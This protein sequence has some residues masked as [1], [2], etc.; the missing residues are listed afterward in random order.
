[1][2]LHELLLLRQCLKNLPPETS[3]PV[4]LPHIQRNK[5]SMYIITIKA[6]AFSFKGIVSRY[7]GLFLFH[8][9][10]LKVIKGLFFISNDIFMFK[11]KCFGGEDPSSQVRNLELFPSG[12]LLERAVP[13]LALHGSKES[14]NRYHPEDVWNAMCQ[15]SHNT[16]VRNPGI[17]MFRR[18]FG[19][20]RANTR[21]TWNN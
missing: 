4:L 3:F 16:G 18:T 8:W 5:T 7:F 19:M 6:K 10:E 12:G 13:T 14:W 15:H 11:K 21:T 2:L 9:I 20:R 17:V 1:V